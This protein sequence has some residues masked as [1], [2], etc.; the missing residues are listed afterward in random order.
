MCN[1]GEGLW[2]R[3]I[4]KGREEGLEKGMQKGMEKGVMEGRAE[5]LAEAIRNVMDSLNLTPEQA[6][7]VLKVP[8]SQRPKY[9]DLLQK[10]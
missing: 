7:T 8:E 6:M 1:L 2:E 5:G 4:K 10:Q 3:A 9:R